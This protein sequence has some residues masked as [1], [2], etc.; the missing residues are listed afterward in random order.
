MR[1]LRLRRSVR[2]VPGVEVAAERLEPAVQDGLAH[3]RGQRLIEGDVVPAEQDLA[4]NFVRAD[5]VVQIGL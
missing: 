1:M 3:R 2:R 5:Q 4:E